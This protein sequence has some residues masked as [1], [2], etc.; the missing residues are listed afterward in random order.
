MPYN[1]ARF[2]SPTNTKLLNEIDS[3]K[4]FDKKYR[5]QKFHEWQRWMYN[6]AYVVPTSGAYSVTAVNSKVSGWSLKPSANVWYEAGFT[7]LIN[8]KEKQYRLVLKRKHRIPDAS[9]FTCQF[10]HTYH[11]HQEHP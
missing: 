1:F 4:S 9:F 10:L 6:K 2:V 11:V 5:V 8:I 7:K 3:A